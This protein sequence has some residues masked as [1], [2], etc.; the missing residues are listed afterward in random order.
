MNV[1]RAETQKGILRRV[2]HLRFEEHMS[3]EDFARCAGVTRSTYLNYIN[4]R[5]SMTVPVLVNIAELTGASLEWIVFGKGDMY[6]PKN[7]NA[8]NRNLFRAEK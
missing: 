7:G 2:E 8:N 5:T 1:K 4:S 6:Y 3:T